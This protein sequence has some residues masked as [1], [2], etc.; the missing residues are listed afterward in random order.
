L[1]WQQLAELWDLARWSAQLLARS[2]AQLS[3]RARSS[4]QRLAR[5]E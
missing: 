5:M 1:L 4:A 3:G 2:S